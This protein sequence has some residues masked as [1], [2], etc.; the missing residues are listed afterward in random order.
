MKKKDYFFTIGIIGLL[1]MLGGFYWMLVEFMS[2]M[3]GE[4]FNSDSLWVTS[5]GFVLLV[6]GLIFME[7]KQLPGPNK[8]F[9]TKDY[10]WVVVLGEYGTEKSEEY[11]VKAPNPA[12][13][14]EEAWKKYSFNK[15][16]IKSVYEDDKNYV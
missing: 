11:K 6:L 4:G 12:L 15:Y 9:T 3:G 7:K 13:A 1:T 14:R 5:I 8:R 10:R 16:Y 2:Y